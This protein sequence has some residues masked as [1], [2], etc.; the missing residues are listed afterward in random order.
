MFCHRCGKELDD[1][2]V[3]CPACGVPTSNYQQHQEPA[4]VVINNTNVNSVNAMVSP[5]SKTVALL[6]CIFLGALGGHRFYVGK[7]GTGIIWLCT[8]GLGGI[9]WLVDLILIIIGSFTDKFGFPLK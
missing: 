3:V 4:Q 7:W 8:F 2:A 5:K 1:S 9:G 6:L